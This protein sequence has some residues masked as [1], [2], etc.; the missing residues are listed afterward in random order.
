MPS[1]K[2][3]E[4]KSETQKMNVVDSATETKSEH[5]DD[6][7]IENT[8]QVNKCH[9]YLSYILNIYIL[10]LKKYVRITTRCHG[11]ISGQCVT[12]IRIYMF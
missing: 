9:K 1:V 4:P 12:N 10:T 2:K 6:E 3:N 5:E 7:V 11:T 8:K